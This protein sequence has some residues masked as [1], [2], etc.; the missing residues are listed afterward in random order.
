MTPDLLLQVLHGLLNSALLSFECVLF[1]IPASLFLAV[2][3]ERSKK[4]SPYTKSILDILISLPSELLLLVLA[5]ILGGGWNVILVCVLLTESPYRI[6]HFGVHLARAYAEEHV[7]AAR[8][9]GANPAT[10]FFKHV[11]P[12]IFMPVCLS[13]LSLIKKVVLLE[14]LLTFLGLGFDPLTVSLG[15]LISVGRDALFYE[16]SQFFVPSISLILFLM[17]L[18][19]LSDKISTLF[20]VKQLRYR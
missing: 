17:L 7:L 6:R 12:R 20:Q 9:L 16:P 14:S 5:G 15:R 2:L 13:V 3:I 4:L 19:L 18:Q 10:I 8:A 1:C 11:L